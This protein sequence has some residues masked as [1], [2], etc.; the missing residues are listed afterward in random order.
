MLP[1]V[2]ALLILQDRDRRLQTLAQDLERLPAEESRAKNELLGDQAAVAA[3][4]EALM[5]AELAVKNTELEAETR[6]N[7]INRLKIQQFETRKNEEYQA[8]GNEIK[9]YENELDQLE[10]KILEGME[11]VDQRR[12]AQEAAK[13]ALERT[14]G[15]VEEELAAIATRRT[16]LEEEGREL[17]AERAQL[18]GAVPGTEALALYDRLT[19]SKA[20]FAV[21]GIAEGRCG[22]CHMKLITSTIIKAQAASGLVQCENCGRILYLAE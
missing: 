10:T 4:H 13:A 11:I 15:I 12:A 18:A 5:A 7:T 8:F 6:R 16:R 9:R 14:R 21:A 17:K 19:R 2:R 1:E 20:G 3:A 22:G